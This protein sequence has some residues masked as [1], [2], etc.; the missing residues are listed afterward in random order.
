MEVFQPGALNAV[1]LSLLDTPGRLWAAASPIRCPTEGRCLISQKSTLGRTSRPR[2]RTCLLTASLLSLQVCRQ[3]EDGGGV[4]VPLRFK[5]PALTADINA[6]GKAW[7]SVE[8]TRGLPRVYSASV[9]CPVGVA[10]SA[11]H[12]R[13][14]SPCSPW[15]QRVARHLHE[16]EQDLATDGTK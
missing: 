16:G 15:W 5:F 8:D 14:M 10:G 7:S 4:F 11:Q 3:E 12:S 2:L 1:G 9:A 13:D 6:T